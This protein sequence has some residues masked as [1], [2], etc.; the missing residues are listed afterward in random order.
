MDEILIAYQP[1]I[2]TLATIKP[3]EETGIKRW[4]L[5]H[6]AVQTLRKKLIEEIPRGK[7]ICR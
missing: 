7:E 4:R 1:Y 3:S 6:D 5:D 2:K